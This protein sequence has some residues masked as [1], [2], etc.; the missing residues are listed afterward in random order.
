VREVSLPGD[1]KYF[2]SVTGG[3][4]EAFFKIFLLE[5]SKQVF[6]LFLLQMERFP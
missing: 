4:D 3:D 5:L 6:N 2:R 1:S